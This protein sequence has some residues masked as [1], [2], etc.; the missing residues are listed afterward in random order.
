MIYLLVGAAMCKP[1]WIDRYLPLLARELVPDVAVVF[2][3]VWAGL[4]FF[5]A[6]LNLL[7]ALTCPIAVWASVMS[8]YGLASKI[9]LFVVG[10]TTMRWIGG[11]RYRTRQTTLA[12]A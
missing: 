1:G 4:M 11:R 7:L 2:E 8:V 5:S 6:A 9:V 10:F 3:F 12:L